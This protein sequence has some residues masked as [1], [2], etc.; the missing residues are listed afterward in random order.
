MLVGGGASVCKRWGWGVGGEA[1][2]LRE[3]DL[4]VKTTGRKSHDPFKLR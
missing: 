1:Q 4:R 3:N 2:T